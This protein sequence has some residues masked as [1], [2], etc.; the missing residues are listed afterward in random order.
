MVAPLKE[1][2][3]GTVTSILDPG[4]VSGDSCPTNDSCGGVDGRADGASVGVGAG[5]GAA[6]GGAARCG[7][8]AAVAVG[9]LAACSG[10][11]PASSKSVN[12][13]MHR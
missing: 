5:A 2:P 6:R 10:G 8:A 1:N 3:G 9:G 11:L 4:T 12:H 13:V 7:S